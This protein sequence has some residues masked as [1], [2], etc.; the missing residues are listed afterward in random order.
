MF[1]F[2]Q[3]LYGN[4]LKNNEI[5]EMMLVQICRPEIWKSMVKQQIMQKQ[6][7]TFKIKGYLKISNIKKSLLARYA[8]NDLYKDINV[9]N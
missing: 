3:L 9:I 7:F 2:G 1:L 4:R 5:I 8:N 6:K